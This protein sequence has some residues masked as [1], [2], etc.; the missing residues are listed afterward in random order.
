LREI[1]IITAMVNTALV[2]IIQPS[3][4]INSGLATII[5][6]NISHKSTS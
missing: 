4:F 5:L 3:C 1:V 6:E 2:C